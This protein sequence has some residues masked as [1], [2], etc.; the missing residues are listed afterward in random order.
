MPVFALILAVFTHKAD[1][2][3]AAMV[4]LKGV[5]LGSPA[6]CAFFLTVATGLPVLPLAAIYAVA[7]VVSGVVSGMIWG[8]LRWMQAKH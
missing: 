7:A 4:L 3:A 2:A 8:L 6:F 5:I 1:G